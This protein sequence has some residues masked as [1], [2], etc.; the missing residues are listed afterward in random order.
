M[1]RELSVAK[2]GGGRILKRVYITIIILETDLV[3]PLGVKS[4]PNPP[5]LV[6][7]SVESPLAVLH[8]FLVLS[9]TS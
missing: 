9:R 2:K 1:R 5:V 3:W 4:D 6:K 7:I 8:S